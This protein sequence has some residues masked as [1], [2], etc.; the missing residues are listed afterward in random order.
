MLEIFLLSPLVS[1]LPVLLPGHLSLHNKG[2]CFYEN[3]INSVVIFLFFS[4]IL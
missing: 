4:Q 2:L 1:D 3:L